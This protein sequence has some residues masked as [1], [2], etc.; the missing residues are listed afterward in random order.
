MTPIMGLDIASRVLAAGQPHT[1][2]VQTKL[3]AWS[4]NETRF[5]G[6]LAIPLPDVISKIASF[7]SLREIA[8]TA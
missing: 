8:K 2:W 5:E 3:N 4:C 1:L 7:G 6:S